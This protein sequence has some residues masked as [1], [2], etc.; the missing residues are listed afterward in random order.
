[1][2]T[3]KTDQ[4][5]KYSKKLVKLQTRLLPLAIRMSLNDAAFHTYQRSKHNAQSKLVMRNKYTL[6]GMRF[7][8][9]RG[10][11]INDM[12]ATTGNV[13]DYMKLQETGGEIEKKGSYLPVPALNARKSKSYKK[14][15]ASRFKMNKL[16]NLKKGSD[17][18]KF[19]VGKTKRSKRLAI[20]QRLRKTKIKVIRWLVSTPKKIK[21]THWLRNAIISSRDMDTFFIHNAKKLI[22][23]RK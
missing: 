3:F 9:A 10:Y 7:N 14:T 23:E 13:R 2:F 6:R 8:K 5:K 1:M 15:I 22:R 18:T 16:G 12:V 20:L 11:N 19:F 21:A 4:I 17:N